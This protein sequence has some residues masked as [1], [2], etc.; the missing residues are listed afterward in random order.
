MSTFLTDAVKNIDD[1]K[2]EETGE[3]LC[4][5][6]NLN[7]NLI[8]RIN[9]NLRKVRIFVRKE[10]TEILNIIVSEDYEVPEGYVKF[11]TAKELKDFYLEY[12]SYARKCKS[13]ESYS[14]PSVPSVSVDHP[15]KVHRKVEDDEYH[16]E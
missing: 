7:A 12:Y 14:K 5:Y 16:G 4:N 9:I 11:D 8:F 2:L 1:L 13:S 15:K 10:L 3:L 6:T